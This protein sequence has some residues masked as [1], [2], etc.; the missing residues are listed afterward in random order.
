LPTLTEAGPAP[1]ALYG[2]SVVVTW[3]ETRI[4]RDEGQ[5]NFDQVN[6]SHNLSIYVS[7]AGRVFSRQ[8][9]STRLGTGSDEQFAGERD[10][11]RVPSFSGRSM[12]I[13]SPFR[14]GG[15]RHFTAEFDS[16]FGTCTAKVTYAT[17][18]GATTS[19]AFSPITKRFVEFQSM[20][21]S[22]AS[23]SIRNGNVF[24]GN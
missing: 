2:K 15:I 11:R 19:V 13:F 17:Q 21:P 14:S 8:T 18:P 1:P 10:S 20:T 3:T 24:G 22:G 4:Q 5:P 23:C 16:N 6:A 9:N 12:E 7:S